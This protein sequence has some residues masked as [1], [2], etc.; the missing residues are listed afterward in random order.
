MSKD[1][2]GVLYSTYWNGYG[3]SWGNKMEWIEVKWQT[4]IL[5]ITSG[6]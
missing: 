3:F 6:F 2:M 1:R 5:E 4:F